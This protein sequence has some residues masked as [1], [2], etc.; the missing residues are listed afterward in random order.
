MDVE[1]P[2]SERTLHLSSYVDRAFDDVVERFRRPGIDELLDS[3]IAVAVGGSQ[4][5][6]VLRASSP[7]TVSHAT[8]RVPVD[9]RFSGAGGGIA[10]GAGVISLLVVQSGRD[11]VTEVLV[12]VAVP[13]EAAHRVAPVLRRFLDELAAR[14]TSGV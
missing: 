6:A 10:E 13:D 4:P 14:L 1:T 12:T 8:A 5:G 7:Q 11:P 9:W 3:S 2:A